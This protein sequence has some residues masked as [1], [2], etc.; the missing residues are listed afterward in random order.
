MTYLDFSICTTQFAMR[1]VRS[2]KRERQSQKIQEEEKIANVNW[3]KTTMVAQQQ[4]ESAKG[5]MISFIF[6]PCV[7]CCWCVGF[8]C[9]R[10]CLLECNKEK[11]TQFQR[12]RTH[13]LAFTSAAASLIVVFSLSLIS[14]TFSFNLVFSSTTHCTRKPVVYHVCLYFLHYHFLVIVPQK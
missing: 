10:C 2:R 7:W 4:R 1:C 13:A 12:Q 14:S 5:Q 6:I 3:L 8:F 11:S 9:C